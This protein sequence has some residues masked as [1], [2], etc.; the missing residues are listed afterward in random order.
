MAEIAVKEM[1][2]EQ[3][4]AE[5]KAIR[6]VLQ[7]AFQEAGATLD[8]SKVTVLGDGDERAKSTQLA[9]MNVRL[10]E[11]GERKNALE[12]AE[13]AREQLD[14]LGGWLDTPKGGAPF[15]GDDQGR[16][17]YKSFADLALPSFEEAAKANRK[18][19][20]FTVPIEGKA[21]IDHEVKTVMSTG[22]GFAP[23]TIRSGIVVPAAFQSPMLLDLIPTVSWPE[24]A[25]PFMR[26]T[27]RTNN[28]AEAA[29]SVQGTLV[30][31]AESAYAWTEISEPLRRIGHYVPVTDQQLKYIAGLRDLIGVDMVDGL[32]E[33]LSSQLLN[34]DGTAP[35]VEGFLDAGRD[36]WDVDTTGEFIA[37]AVDKLIEKV[38]VSGF[39]EC[40]AV[41][42]NRGD[43]HG[44]RR[45]TTADGIYIAGHPSENVRPSMWGLPVIL[46][47]EIAAG[48]ALAGAF[49]RFSKIVLGSGMEVSVSNEHND[50]FIQGLNA[51]KAEVYATLAVMR[52][53]AFA[54]TNDIVVS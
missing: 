33:R 4:A 47:T 54:K 9:N 53:T 38:A 48:S 21:F 8:M 13:K 46:T 16:P 11:L 6:P 25:Y 19:F 17:R 22:A 52:E 49:A 40:D 45:A 28:A 27:T 44:Y 26:Q 5:V 34:G 41:I 10:S 23:P 36:T 7:K 3:V 42:M 39:A 37:D 51:I 30:S 12:S 50:Y 1:T 20:E 32:R 31:L 15:P 35:N 24:S 43:W 14:E 29:E 18:K 2:L